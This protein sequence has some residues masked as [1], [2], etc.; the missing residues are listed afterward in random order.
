MR[1]NAGQKASSIRFYSPLMTPQNLETE[2]EWHVEYVRCLMNKQIYT[3]KNP[4][5]NT[6][7]DISSLEF[8][9]VGCG[10]GFWHDSALTMLT[11]SSENVLTKV[12]HMVANRKWQWQKQ[13]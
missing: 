9:F 2:R 6:R 7:F 1:E 12:M 4:T 13:I 5:G 11:Y 8:D 3:N 10:G